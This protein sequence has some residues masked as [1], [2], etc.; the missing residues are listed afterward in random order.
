ML[1]WVIIDE[2]PSVNALIGGTIIFSSIVI[3]GIWGSKNDKKSTS[4]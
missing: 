4:I 3:M 1:V 2:A